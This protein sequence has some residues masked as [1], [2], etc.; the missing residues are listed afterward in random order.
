M[1]LLNPILRAS[2]IRVS[3]STSVGFRIVFICAAVYVLWTVVSSAVTGGVSSLGLAMLV[4]CLFGAIYL[5]RWTIDR[6]TGMFEKN[7]GVLFLHTHRRVRVCDI[8]Q[9][10]LQLSWDQDNASHRA[11]GPRRFARLS[12][13]DCN[14]NE[15]M[16]DVAR[17]A[18]AGQLRQ[19]A[20]AVS[21]F[22]NIPLDIITGSG[23]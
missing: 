18:A 20:E 23:A 10:L 19:T 16:L 21:G 4:V 13:I 14:R 5:E 15:V 8:Q 12:L 2:D 22:C 11:R 3:Y 7:V 9:V 1:S 6:R 17:G